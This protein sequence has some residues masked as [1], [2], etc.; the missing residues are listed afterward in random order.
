MNPILQ[1]AFQLTILVLSQ[2][3]G[4]S[5][6]AA[7]A[8]TSGSGR[9]ISVVEVFVDTYF[10]AD[11]TT[12]PV[13]ATSD[14]GAVFSVSTNNSLRTIKVDSSGGFEWVCHRKVSS[15]SPGLSTYYPKAIVEDTTDLSN[16]YVYV[17]G[18]INSTKGF[19]IKY[20]RD[21][22]TYVYS[23]IFYT[24][25][26]EKH[27][28]S[29]LVDSS[30]NLV[31]A[32]SYVQSSGSL[33]WFAKIDKSTLASTEYTTNTYSAT[34][35]TSISRLRF[36][37]VLDGSDVSDIYLLAGTISNADSTHVYPWFGAM[38]KSTQALLWKNNLTSGELIE[39]VRA[40]TEKY[41]VLTYDEKEGTYCYSVGD[42]SSG[43]SPTAF[44]QGNS[45]VYSTFALGEDEKTAIVIGFNYS[46]NRSAA[47]LYDASMN[48][49]YDQDTTSEHP[50]IHLLAS[51]RHASYTN[52]VWAAGYAGNLT[53]ISLIVKL[54]PQANTVASCGD[55]CTNYLD[56]GCYQSTT[57]GCSA[58]CTSCL[59][60]GDSDACVASSE[61]ADPFATALFAARCNVS[62]QAYNSTAELCQNVMVSSSC[63][64][65]CGG[66]CLAPS[67]NTKCAGH[68]VNSVFEPYIDDSAL[69]SSN[70]CKCRIGTVY[71]SAT[72]ACELVTDCSALCGAGG[73]GKSNDSTACV[74]CIASSGT[75]SVTG[76]EYVECKCMFN[77]VLYDGECQT[78]SEFCDGCTL[79]ADSTRCLKCNSTI[80]NVQQS[81]KSSPYTC[82]CPED[83]SY[84]DTSVLAGGICIY[85]SNCNALCPG[86]CLSQNS[87]SA[88]IGGCQSWIT[89]PVY[90]SRN[91]TAT[92]ACTNGTVYN[93]GT[94]CVLN[95]TANCHPLCGESCT[96]EN[97][98]SKCVSACVSASNVLTTSVEGEIVACSCTADAHLT[99]QYECALNITCDAL[100]E[101]CLNSDT[102]L[103]CPEEEG[104]VLVDGRC[105]CAVS[106]GYVIVADSE[107]G[108]SHCVKKT[109][110]TSD[111]AKYSA[112]ILRLNF[113]EER[114][115]PCS[116]LQQGSYQARAV[117]CLSLKSIVVAFW[118][119]LNM[120][121]EI[122]LLAVIN[123]KYMSENLIAAFQGGSFV[124]FNVFSW[125]ISNL[126][127]EYQGEVGYN[128]L[129]DNSQYHPYIF[130]A[131]DIHDCAASCFPIV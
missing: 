80:T 88:C 46:S 25:S 118:K 53:G 119:F 34:S 116:S 29:L 42:I 122:I 50:M 101:N 35:D 54:E 102:C 7:V 125:L 89:S 73:C 83:V 74:D 27:V 39:A 99:A 130:S 3:V 60:V 11:G 93:N 48:A 38:S 47:F 120:E 72:S 71:N 45:D 128:A 8:T 30:G 37:R 95:S 5:A 110:V 85:T 1:I 41:A 51:S 79:P 107:T 124:N 14:G 57:S 17:G 121:Q 58:L 18:D 69:V 96:A 20:R 28:N 61:E 26:V 67:D 43:A 77:T 105:V 108:Y 86:E 6:R 87:A 44:S 117:S 63:H 100:C 62:G 49:I 109:S 97:D 70:T 113:V 111:I 64:P 16:V 15:D 131:T 126:P 31:L 52:I 82:A 103:T 114:Q 40:T 94:T 91:F 33:G 59:I 24:T 106:Q 2:Y 112:Y 76:S 129:D 23:K 4:F 21:K 92:C 10:A 32:G 55:G 75:V 19:V 9:P 84:Y 56:K 22:G 66:E 90:D 36:L 78:C 13:L 98:P 68:C 115:A 65:L 123:T 104:T 127:A 81:G 12:V